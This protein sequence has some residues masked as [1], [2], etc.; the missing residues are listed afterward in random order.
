MSTDTDHA[1]A[2]DELRAAIDGMIRGIRDPEAALRALERLSFEREELRK[3]IGT[4]EVAVDLI[5]E[6]RGE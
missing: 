4:I 1:A 5:R 6:G 3:K 2:M